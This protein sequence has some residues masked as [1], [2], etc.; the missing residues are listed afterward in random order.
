L[1]PD[2]QDYLEDQLDQVSLENLEVQLDRDFPEG[3]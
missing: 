1:D 3:P 2:F